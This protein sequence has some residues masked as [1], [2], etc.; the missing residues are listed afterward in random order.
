[1]DRRLLGGGLVRE[2]DGIETAGTDD[3]RLHWMLLVL[4]G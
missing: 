3:E 4:T 1:M 2:S